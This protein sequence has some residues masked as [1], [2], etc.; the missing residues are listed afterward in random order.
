[1]KK[2]TFKQLQKDI[3]QSKPSPSQEYPALCNCDPITMKDP[4]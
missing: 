2:K 4:Y 3:Q 1:M